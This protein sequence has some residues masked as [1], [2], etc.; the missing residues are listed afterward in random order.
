MNFTKPLFDSRLLSLP[1]DRLVA[2]AFEC[3]NPAE[4]VENFRG[5]LFHEFE[6]IF[7]DCCGLPQE[8]WLRENELEFNPLAK[9]IQGAFI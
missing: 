5:D 6:T 1:D 7:M 4:E 3:T 2:V 8:E 9:Q